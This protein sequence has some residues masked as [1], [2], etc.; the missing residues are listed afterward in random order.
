MKIKTVIGFLL[1]ISTIY[2]CKNHEV[3]KKITELDS[4]FHQLDSTGKIYL[5]IDG[6]KFDSVYLHITNNVS[7]LQKNY[8]DTMTTEMLSSV[9]EYNSIRNV[10][11]VYKNNETTTL[12]GLKNS[13]EQISNLL[14][15]LKNS[16]IKE[17]QTIKL[18]EKETTAAIKIIQSIAIT[19]S[20]LKES[21]KKF[22]E[23]NPKIQD[24][25]TITE[26]KQNLEEKK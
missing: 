9:S 3:E 25:I 22:D 16:L 12:N 17:E 23:L 11:E 2:G 6:N 15:D 7:Y 19:D 8:K 1:I 5:S 24:L 21:I 10:I 18:I 13:K 20:I 14:H 26:E 4:T